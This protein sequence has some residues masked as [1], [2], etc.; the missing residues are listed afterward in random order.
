M[1]TH[2]QHDSSSRL[3]EGRA[4]GSSPEQAFVWVFLILALAVQTMFTAMYFRGLMSSR[5]PFL[6][7][8]SGAVDAGGAS[9]ILMDVFGALLL[10]LGLAYGL[11]RY[12][13]RDKRLDPLTEA[14]T[15]DAYEHP[16]SA[17]R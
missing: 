3:Q 17:G 7:G 15:R 4:G 1:P 13:T 6:A 16:Q 12:Y 2:T 14:A 5:A 8:P 9:W 10:G 11:F